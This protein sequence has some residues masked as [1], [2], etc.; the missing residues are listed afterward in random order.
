MGKDVQLNSFLEEGVVELLQRAFGDFDY[1]QVAKDIV[2]RIQ[3]NSLKYRADKASAALERKRRIAEEE[4]R[5]PPYAGTGRPG[6]PVSAEQMAR[7]MELRAQGLA[8]RAIGKEVGLS[9]M[10]V[11]RRLEECEIL[12]HQLGD[13]L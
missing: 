3:D 9:H 4:E 1:A 2:N 12:Q 13:F 7:I 11:R 6:V 8:L 10:V 5:Y